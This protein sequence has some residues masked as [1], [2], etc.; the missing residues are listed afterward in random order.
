MSIENENIAE[1]AIENNTPEAIAPARPEYIPEK[2]WNPQNNQIR[3]EEMAKSYI[4]LEKQFS[5]KSNQSDEINQLNEQSL[6]WLGLLYADGC[7]SRQGNRFYTHISLQENDGY[8]IEK[9]RE[10][11]SKDLKIK[12]RIIKINS[13]ISLQKVISI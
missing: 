10:F 5:K 4:E 11:V 8:L 13:G 1:E 3:I 7:I 9:L 6:Y 2:F 12:T